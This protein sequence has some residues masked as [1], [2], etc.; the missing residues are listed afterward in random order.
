MVAHQ[1]PKDVT[2]SHAQRTDI[3][4]SI[5]KKKKNM[6]CK[7]MQHIYMWNIGH[8]VGQV[9]VCDLAAR[10][11]ALGFDGDAQHAAVKAARPGCGP[12]VFW[13]GLK[14]P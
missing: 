1:R 10:L 7:S 4:Q 3:H 12:C 9:T 11:T 2:L 8:L 5:L 6:N 13:S 14:I